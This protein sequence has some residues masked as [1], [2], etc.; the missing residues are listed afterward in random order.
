LHY[1]A[2]TVV[3]NVVKLSASAGHLFKAGK[4]SLSSHNHMNRSGA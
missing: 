4:K 2:Y 3:Y 1:S